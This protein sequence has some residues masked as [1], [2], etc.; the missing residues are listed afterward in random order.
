MKFSQFMQLLM[1]NMKKLKKKFE[2]QGVHIRA[3]QKIHYFKSNVVGR[4]KGDKKWNCI[5]FK[6]ID[7]SIDFKIDLEHS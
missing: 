7:F 5:L 1:K 2:G 4:F 3:F 6:I